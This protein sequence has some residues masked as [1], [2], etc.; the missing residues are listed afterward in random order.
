MIIQPLFG[1]AQTPTFPTA[2]A[3]GQPEDKVSL[4]PPDRNCW[5][6]PNLKQA[7]ASGETVSAAAQTAIDTMREGA[8]T[9]MVVA[10]GMPHLGWHRPA[11]PGPFRSVDHH[12]T[13]ENEGTSVTVNFT[14][15][16]GHLAPVTPGETDVP[17][18]ITLGEGQPLNNKELDGLMNSLYSRYSR[19]MSEED[20]STLQ[21]LI[22]T[23]AAVRFKEG[24][25]EQVAARH[26]VCSQSIVQPQICF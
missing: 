2:A 25:P 20:A 23:T 10:K 8:I 1:L 11:A 9:K 14:T 4:Y 13:F 15:G 18:S 17:G 7:G 5:I 12:V 6:P 16:M 22:N 3:S 26:Q 24:S 19:K 21:H